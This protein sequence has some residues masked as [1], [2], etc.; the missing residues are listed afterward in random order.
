M[1][2]LIKKKR[3]KVKAIFDRHGY[4]I[5]EEVFISFFKLMYAED[6][7]LIQEKWYDEEKNTPPGKKHSMPHPDIYMHE[8]YRNW[9]G[10]S[11]EENWKSR[12]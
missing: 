5:S 3:E 2:S 4:D 1:G 10:R 8:M 7:E 12:R 6:W 11:K 9:S